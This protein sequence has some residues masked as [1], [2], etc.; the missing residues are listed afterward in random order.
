[1]S[2][3]IECE[4]FENVKFVMRDTCKFLAKSLKNL[5][6]SFEIPEEYSKGEMN[7]NAVNEANWQELKPIWEPYVE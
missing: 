7:H 3:E 2:L 4:Q 6:K 5:C 1:M